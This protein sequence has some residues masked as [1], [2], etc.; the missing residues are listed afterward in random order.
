MIL[1]TGAT[2]H[3]GAA[4]V[5]ALGQQAADLRLLVRSPDKVL[6]LAGLSDD[7]ARLASGEIAIGDLRDEAALAQAME[8]VEA[9]IHCAHSH[10]YWRGS[11]YLYAV[12]VG[13]AQ[14]LAQAARR[15]GSVQQVIFISSYSC[16]HATHD[17]AREPALRRL[18]PRELSSK[19]KLAAGYYLAEGA[20]A[21]AY[22]LHLVSPSYM[23]GPYQ[24][25]PTYFGALFHLVLFRP[26]RWCPPHGINLVDVRDVARA[27]VGCLGATSAQ[28]ILATGDNVTYADLFASMNRA[29]GFLDVP[30][31]IAPWVFRHLPRLR[32]FGQ[33]GQQYFQKA[34]FVADPGLATRGFHLDASVQDAVEWARRQQLFTSGFDIL[35]FMVRRYF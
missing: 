13:G 4:I 19:A 33:F 30:R 27:T 25:D 12:N 10:E 21:G 1:L 31:Q 9:V 14:A 24:L 15:V 20:A 34:H 22:T 29:G 7:F 18:A 6:Q 5:T 28:K 2:G 8:G 35:R 23:I 11:E 3:L 16:H 32:V 26:L 17:P